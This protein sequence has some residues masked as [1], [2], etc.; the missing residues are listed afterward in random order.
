MAR[1]AAPQAQ[2]LAAILRRAQGGLAAALLDFLLP[3]ACFGCGRPLGLH[4]HLGACPECWSALPLAGPCCPGCGLPHAAA[5]DLLGRPGARCA[6]CRLTPRPVGRVHTVTVYEGIAR[7][8][9][10]RAKLGRR[11]E[12]L[13]ALGAQLARVLAAGGAGSECASVVPVPSHPWSRLRR[14]FD[15]ALELARPVASTL[16]RPLTPGVLRRRV[17]AGQP[18]KRFGADRRLRVAAEAFRLAG[19]VRGPCVL[20]VDDVM[21]TGATIEACARLLRAGGAREVVAA[22]WARTLPEDTGCPP[23]PPGG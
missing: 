21:T 5:S 2:G 1:S 6:R 18:L 16:G 11:P 20:L 17:R 14:G 15:P 22:V 3:A 4:W 10:L 7:A 12:L 9:L 8:F 23:L 13:A 19:R